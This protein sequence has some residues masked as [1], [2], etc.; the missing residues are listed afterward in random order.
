MLVNITNYEHMKKG[1]FIKEESDD[2]LLIEIKVKL[3]PRK[4]RRINN[5]DSD[6]D[7]DMVSEYVSIPKQ[8]VKPNIYYEFIQYYTPQLI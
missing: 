5:N 4:R 1:L 7:F 3:P 2:N 8:H 6:E